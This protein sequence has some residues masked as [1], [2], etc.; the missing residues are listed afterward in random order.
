MATYVDES[1]IKAT[2]DSSDF[3]RNI[4]A[5]IKSIEEFNKSLKFENSAKSLE[6]LA[7]ATDKLSFE[8]LRNG[9]QEIQRQVSSINN[10]FTNPILR[11]VR[12]IED[13]LVQAA[14]RF[15]KSATIDPIVKGWDQYADKTQAVQTILAALPEEA[16]DIDYVN[17]RMDKLNWYA[18]E[19]SAKLSDMTGNIGK[20]TAAGIGLDE[21]VTAMIGI[22]NW[23]YEAGQNVQKAGVAMYQ[24]S[25]ALGAG[26]VKVQDWMSIERANMATKEFKNIA[27]EAGKSVGTLT[28]LGEVVTT[29][30]N[31]L[32]PVTVT[33][34]NFRNTLK[35]GW[36][37]ND[38]LIKALQEYGTVTEKVNKIWE[39]TERSFLT[40]D[41]LNSIEAF[42]KGNEKA[43]DSFSAY[44]DAVDM[45]KELSKE[46]GS[47]GWNALRAA[48]EAVTFEQAIDSIA[49]A[50]KSKWSQI[51]ETI[52]GSYTEVKNT[53]TKLAED[54]WKIL[55]APVDNLLITL[56]DAFDN[57]LDKVFTKFS[58][59]TDAL[60]VNYLL[61]KIIATAIVMV[62]NFVTRKLFLE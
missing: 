59:G 26:S 11:E 1:R 60:K 53:W 8:G 48:Q 58:V 28:S 13:S 24:L 4:Q 47:V 31:K 56:K 15:I 30:D 5:S 23:A 34:D 33:A 49:E 50:A 37:T 22:S 19:T 39:A 27:I 62:F 21:S 36:L 7:S 51:F 29:L 3:D 12:K 14:E 38:V 2:W 57:P 9:M 16:K 35:E 25:Q 61:V 43:L 20:F 17:S 10:W 46:V 32:G 18:D 6:T 52:F 44:S 41:I 54:L 42:A 55:V 45:M 40:S